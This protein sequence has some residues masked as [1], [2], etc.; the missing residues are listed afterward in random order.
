[1]DISYQIILI[2][3]LLLLIS[4]LATSYS[5]RIGM[6]I[7]LVFLIIGILAGE[8]GPGTIQFQNMHT[9]HLIGVLALAIILLDAGLHTKIS[10]FSGGLL[11]ALTLASIGILIT[12][13]LIGLFS[14]WL[15]HLSWLEGLLLGAILSP[16]DAAAVFL[17]LHSS[18]VKLMLKPQVVATLEI[19][20]GSNDPLAVLLTTSLIQ[21]LQHHDTPIMAI[22]KAFLLEIGLG[23]LIGLVAGLIIIWFSNRIKLAESLYPLLVL[24]G[25]LFIFAATNLL[26]G[27]GYI[28]LYLAAI[29]IGNSQIHHH[30]NILRL[31]DSLAWLSQISMFLMLGLLVTP[32][33][34]VPDMLDALFIALALIVIARPTAVW[35]SLLP[36]TF[37]GFEKVFIAWTGLRG[38][39]P[40]IL[41]I[42]PLLA[43]LKHA[44]LYFNITF[45]VV[46]IS[47]ILQGWPLPVVARWLKVK[48]NS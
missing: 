42:N 40:I 24:S 12:S 8:Q 45:F 13:I 9:A 26:G 15:L 16:T 44:A 34:L 25:S 19:E 36:F 38:A 1:M 27:S 23:T 5:S 6:P 10:S 29:I 47:I 33:A 17:L 32:S 4:I 35:I 14:S 2:G 43:G 30:E 7:L 20:S 18:W 48:V 3:A 31:H 28:A 21:V 11:P 39:V 37:T 41:A 22:L 46:V